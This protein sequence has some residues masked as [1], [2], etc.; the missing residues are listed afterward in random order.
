MRPIPAI[1]TAIRISDDA[2]AGLFRIRGI[3]VSCV[4]DIFNSHIRAGIRQNLPDNACDICL[5]RF[6]VT[7]IPRNGIG[8]GY[9]TTT[10]IK[11][12]DQ[13][14]NTRP[15]GASYIA[16]IDRLSTITVGRIKR[17][18]KPSGKA[19]DIIPASGDISPVVGMFNGPLALANDSADLATAGNCKIVI[20]RISGKDTAIQITDYTSN[21]RSSA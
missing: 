16:G 15:A 13:T 19:A 20:Y 10:I 18:A 17:S 1:V 8:I 12:T 14:A 4:Y 6:Y 11:R 21:V 7:L 9:K 5:I 2:A 3:N